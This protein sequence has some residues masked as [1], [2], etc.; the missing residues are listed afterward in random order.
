MRRTKFATRLNS[1]KSL[2]LDLNGFAMRYYSEPA[3]KLGAFTNPDAAIGRKA[4]DL[5]KRGLDAMRRAGRL[6]A[7]RGG[8]RQVGFRGPLTYRSPMILDLQ[9]RR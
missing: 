4:I 5:I 2:G 3:F 8:G 9:Q 6:S 7:R 1:F